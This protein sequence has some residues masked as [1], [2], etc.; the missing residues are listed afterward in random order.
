MSCSKLLNQLA[1]DFA[2]VVPT[3]DADVEHDRWDAG[4]GPFEEDRQIEML[5]E[6][7]EKDIRY[8]IKTEEPYPEG[9][10]Q[11]DLFIQREETVIPVEAKLLR[12]RYDNGN[13]DPNSFAKVFSPFPERTTS[14]L[15]TDARKLNEANFEKT[16][17]LL[18]LYYEPFDEPYERMTPESIAEKF[19]F[20]VSY[21]YDF[22]VETR[23]VAYFE[24]LRHPVHQ[25]GAII[26][27]EIIDPM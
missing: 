27:W 4:I 15:L 25:H 13:I 1:D 3:I 23:N 26:T 9:G 14:T 7:V 11:V 21:W 22:E 6:T 5:R 8:S 17:G 10:Q 19:C 18:G 2:S 24:G 16:G 20:D 12:F